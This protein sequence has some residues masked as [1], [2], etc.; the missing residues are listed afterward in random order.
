MSANTSNR[1]SHD[2]QEAAWTSR[3][4]TDLLDERRCG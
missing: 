3:V 4:D 1:D 2:S